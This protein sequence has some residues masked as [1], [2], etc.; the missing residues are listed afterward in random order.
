MKNIVTLIIILS[1]SIS[2]FAQ[3]GINYKAVIKD[4]LGNVVAN[5]NIDI[6]FTI[7][8]NDI[9]FGIITGYRE[10]QNTT[11]DA[12]GIIV[13]NIGE[14]TLLFGSFPEN[15]WYD[16][17]YLITEIDI[18]TD[19]TFITLPTTII[20]DV[21]MAKQ[22]RFA[23]T[24]SQASFASTANFANTAAIANN[25]SG[26]EQIT[27]GGNTGW[28]LVG[29]DPN[30]FGP[31]GSAAIDLSYSP[32]LSETRGA[33]G[34]NSIALGIGTHASDL[35][36]MAM[37]YNTTAS[38]SVSTAMG[39]ATTASGA[40]STAMGDNTTASG[41]VSTAIG[42]Q[43]TASG[44]GS[45]AMGFQTKAES[46]RSTAIGRFNIGGATTN[47]DTNWF[48]ADPLF[49]VGN[50]DHL[51]SRNNA[52]TIYKNGNAEFDGEIQHTSTG[53]A[54]M[55]PLAYGTVDSNGDIETGTGNF[56]AFLSGNVFIIDVNGTE[57]L[58]YG[59]TVC[60]I[61]PI[62]TAARTASTIITDGNGDGDADLNVRIFNA[63][64]TQVLTTFQFVIY[65][66]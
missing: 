13:L 59:N 28:R 27:E 57:A 46:Y 4:D 15:S 65:K 26:L 6:R 19:G 2:S 39:F 14:G 35:A 51:N 5:Q 21:P 25:V 18:E 24:A 60:L 8:F 31:I 44:V 33:T 20:N 50:G 66:L 41:A 61:T 30:N 45:T 56:T 17:S 9:E 3:T 53:N 16:E 11:T 58:S 54:N 10:I 1:I 63:S 12:N 7:E 37:G 22:A 55:I 42:S 40:L 52:L 47:G 32:S 38:E 48:S 43:T 23:D 64:G 34:E 36:S 29:T 62:S 49:E